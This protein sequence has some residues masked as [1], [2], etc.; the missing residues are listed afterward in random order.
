MLAS[1]RPVQPDWVSPKERSW[2]GLELRVFSGRDGLDIRKYCAGLRLLTNSC[3]NQNLWVIPSDLLG[4]VQNLETAETQ[5]HLC[6][7]Y[8]LRFAGPSE[9][10]DTSLP[11]APS[12]TFISTTEQ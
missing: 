9:I 3:N 8:L 12:R 5:G 6:I 2:E 10:F 7:L 1:T 11:F 4:A